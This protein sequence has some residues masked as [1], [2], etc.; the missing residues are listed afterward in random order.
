VAVGAWDLTLRVLSAPD[1]IERLR[2]P[3]AADVV[4]RSV[5][6]A[7]LDDV[8]F[9]LVGL[10][11]GKLTTF[12]FDAT[13]GKLS[14]RKT[15]A[16]GTQPISLTPFSARGGAH[17]FAC[18]DRPNVISASNKKLI[19]SNVNM[20]VAPPPPVSS[21]PPPQDILVMSPFNAES[22]PDCLAVATDG[23]LTLGN[24]DDIQ[25]LHIRT[26]PLGEQPRRIAH[27]EGARAFVVLTVRSSIGDKGEEREEAFIKLLD[28]QTFERE[29][30]GG[31]VSCAA[32]IFIY[33]F[34]FMWFLCGFFL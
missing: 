32:V 10:G 30:E 9:V 1:L 3:V 14:D 20:K 33:L 5:I 12:Q 24:V 15:M 19:I 34:I 13:H 7:T 4:P 31:S 29:R 23:A 27:V 8:D 16:V 26:V 11:D 22:F 18:G 17:V 25:K 6:L 28:D 21:P 2:E